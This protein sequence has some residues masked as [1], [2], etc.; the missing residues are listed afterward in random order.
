MRDEATDFDDSKEAEVCNQLADW[1]KV[2]Q[3]D[4]NDCAVSMELTDWVGDCPT[5]AD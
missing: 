2:R 5:A 1:E 4:L 3:H